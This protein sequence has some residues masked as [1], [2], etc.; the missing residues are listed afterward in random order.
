VKRVEE[1]RIAQLERKVGQ[2][3]LEIRSK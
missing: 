1:E 3:A 2:H